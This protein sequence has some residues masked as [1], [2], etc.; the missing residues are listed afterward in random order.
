MESRLL[1]CCRGVKRCQWPYSTPGRTQE[2]PD[3]ARSQRPTHWRTA[4]RARLKNEDLYVKQNEHSSYSL[5][6]FW[7]LEIL[8]C[9]A[10]FAT[11]GLQHILYCNRS[12][13][14]QSTEE[15]WESCVGNAGLCDK[16]SD[17]CWSHSKIINSAENAS[18]A[19]WGL[20][21]FIPTKP[22]NGKYIFCWL[23]GQSL[24]NVSFVSMTMD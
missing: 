19:N 2:N 10:Q 23:T 8:K 11:I 5:Q 16:S 14:V 4:E 22:K 20:F 21:I 17:K 1:Q 12:A 13:P 3:P 18:R 7:N 15:L 6:L 24:K 9:A